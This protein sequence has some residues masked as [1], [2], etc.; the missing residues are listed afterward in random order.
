MNREEREKKLKEVSEQLD[1]MLRYVKEVAMRKAT[2]AIDN[3]PETYKEERN[4][5]LSKAVLDSV[6]RDRPYA[7]FNSLSKKEFDN[8]HLTC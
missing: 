6:C 8:I 1:E 4:W 7:A 3:S 5:L 2:N